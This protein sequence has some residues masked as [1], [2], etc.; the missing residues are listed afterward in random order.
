[1]R[2]RMGN[3]DAAWFRMDRPRNAADVV[4]LLSFKALPPV[5]KVRALVR[6][7][8]LSVPRFTQRAVRGGLLGGDRWADDPDFRLDRHLLEARLAGSGDGALQDF[9]SSAMSDALD[10]D[11][12]LWRFTLVTTPDRAAVVVKLS[13]C[14]ADG[15]ALI[16]LLLSL[17]DELRER[18]PPAAAHV[19][20]A[21]RRLEPWLHPAKSLRAAATD[22]ARALA[23]AREAAGLGASI[24][25]IAALPAD[26]ETVLSRPLTGHR[27]AAW[28]A[29]LPLTRLRDLGRARG[30]TVNDVILAA[31]AGAVRHHLVGSGEAVNGL[32]L[33]ALVPVNLRPGPPEL[34]GGSLG[35][36]FGL[37][38]VRLP[39]G[40]R[41]PALRLQAVQAETSIIKGRPDAVATLGLLGAMGR[42]PVVEPWASR[43]FSRKASIVVTNVPGPHRPLHLA[44]ERIES[45]MFWVPHPSTLGLGLSVLTYAGEVRIGVRSDTGVLPDPGLLA[46]LFEPELAALE[47]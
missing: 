39:I 44:G 6:E 19:L 32:S 41:S 2:E 11:R 26:P 35:N 34:S 38:F 43:F 20:P 13:H 18:E 1:M 33:R 9:V 30:C 37:V 4:A 23:L 17:C 7:R 3:V 27:R 8:L 45:A 31:V 36:Q 22:P 47:A 29:G 40:E 10:P 15:F 25:R 28:S 21:H 46:G 16:G 42:V 5:E 24:A 14:M 12:P